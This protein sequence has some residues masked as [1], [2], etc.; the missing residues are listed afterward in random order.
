MILGFR[1]NLRT[2]SLAVL[3]AA[4]LLLAACGRQTTDPEQPPNLG[5]RAL[6]GTIQDWPGGAAEITAQ[7]YR[8]DFRVEVIAS[9]E[10]NDQGG[11]SL[12]LPDSLREALLF[13]LPPELLQYCENLNVSEPQARGN[14]IA[15]LEAYRG[16]DML[17]A[18][19]Q[20]SALDWAD[21]WTGAPPTGTSAVGRVYVDRDVSVTGSCEDQFLGLSA[22][23]EVDLEA[24]WNIVV[25]RVT[26]STEARLGVEVKTEPVPDAVGWH[27]W[28]P[29]A[30]PPP[31]PPPPVEPD[32]FEPNDSPEEAT[33]I[34]LDFS[35]YSPQL[36]ITPG[37]VDW[38]TFTLAEAASF[39]ANLSFWSYEPFDPVMSLF[40][41]GLAEVAGG[42]WGYLETA[43]EAGTYYLAVSSYPDAGFAGDHEQQGFY[44]LSTY[45][46]TEAPP[47]PELP[48][49]PADLTAETLDGEV[50][51]SWQAS[52]GA[53]GYNVYRSESPGVDLGAAHRRNATLVGLTAFVDDQVE[54]GVTYYY[55]VTAVGPS[56]ESA[57]S[58][59]GS[60]TPGE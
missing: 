2:P 13:S 52:A 17:G 16:A 24:G 44:F 5:A 42:E 15:W 10:V 18:V 1:S 32:E 6:S 54:N 51:L 9:G 14:I 22:S 28:V 8:P 47:P 19:V 27:L 34:P 26:E 55:V 31:P 36:T 46:E 38:F 33:P 20:I 45:A 35:W 41:S 37:D 56:G 50:L 21:E 29:P 59:E 60:A 57:A 40:D 3:V 43:L 23:F 12:T 4:V 30:P 49:P 39:S 58:N 48:D 7:V 53:D 11:F 25:V